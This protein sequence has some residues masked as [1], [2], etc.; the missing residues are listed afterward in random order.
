MGEGVAQG[1]SAGSA[2]VDPG[3]HKGLG[4]PETNWG[5][6]TVVFTYTLCTGKP[7]HMSQIPD[8]AGRT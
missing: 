1:P 2:Y 4:W 6:G 8:Q 3:L 5:M 7:N